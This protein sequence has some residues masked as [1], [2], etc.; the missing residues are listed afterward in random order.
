ME[1]G[2]ALQCAALF[3]PMQINA[4]FAQRAAV[5][6][7][8][9]PWV[10]SP[11]PG[12]ERRMLDRI[13]GEVA[14]ATSMVRY[15]P[16]SSFAAHTHGG[17][18]EFFVLD[19][20]FEDEHGAFSAG[21]YVRNPPDTSHTPRSATGCTMLVKLWQFGPADRHPVA[22]A[23]RENLFEP[24]RARHA[25]ETLP[26]FEN[27]FECVRLERWAAHREIK[28]AL[29]GG[30][31]FFVIEGTFSERDE[32]FA[33]MSWLRL[34]PGDTLNATSGPLGAKVW[35]KTGHLLHLPPLPGI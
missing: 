10:P 27:A 19:G 23:T 7:A 34:P 12:V 15:A 26:L 32:T 18:E 28:L 21:A 9:T 20:V 2:R 29:A 22:V 30:G 8:G 16:N 25:V 31:E 5:H 17:G 35:I 24:D 3:P 33:A 4:D 1:R 13:G 14:R 11:I 6:A